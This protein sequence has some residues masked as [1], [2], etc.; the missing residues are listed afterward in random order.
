M[1]R[2]LKKDVPRLNESVNDL[3]KELFSARPETVPMDSVNTV[4]R[5]LVSK[6]VMLSESANDLKNELFSERVEA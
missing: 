4:L 5:P 2:P 6:V 1:V 3:K